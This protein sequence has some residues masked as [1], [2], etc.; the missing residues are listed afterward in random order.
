MRLRENGV[1]VDGRGVL[2]T[3]TMDPPTWVLWTQKV[4]S[5]FGLK[6]TPDSER[7]D[8]G[9]KVGSNIELRDDPATTHM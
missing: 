2:T 1:E 9:A 7:E 6:A 5:A 4:R 8:D 3:R